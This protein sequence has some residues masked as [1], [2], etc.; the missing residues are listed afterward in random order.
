MVVAFVGSG[1][2]GVSHLNGSGEN[3]C[4]LSVYTWGWY[5]LHIGQ[6]LSSRLSGC[7]YRCA[8]SVCTSFYH[9]T[10]G[11]LRLSGCIHRCV[12]SVSVYQFLLMTPLMSSRLSGCVHRCV[13]GVNSFT[14]QCVPGFTSN[15][16][17]VNIDDCKVNDCRNGA[18]CNDLVSACS[19][20]CRVC[21]TLYRF[22]CITLKYCPAFYVVPF[23]DS[24][25]FYVPPFKDSSA[26]YV[27][28]FEDIS[29]FY[30]S[31]FIPLYVY[32]HMFITGEWLQLYLRG[33][34]D[35]PVVR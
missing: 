8:A 15:T 26:F 10:F 7:V 9:Y 25:V 12:D 30:V 4:F 17:G 14:C 34:L 19:L 33:G 1:G 23:E 28:P 29:A 27:L 11:V 24:P 20:W 5:Q 16:C 35:W 3:L 13:D 31:P 32:V 21:M 6:F 2:V 22:L 18:T